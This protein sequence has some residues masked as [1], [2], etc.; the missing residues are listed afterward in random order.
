MLGVGE[1]AFDPLN[2]AERIDPE[3]RDCRLL[4]VATGFE[5]IAASSHDC[6]CVVAEPSS[7]RKRHA[8]RG[9]SQ[10]HLLQ[11]ALTAV[12]EHPLLRA[13]LPDDEIETVPVGIATGVLCR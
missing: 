5:R 12:Q 1:A 7:H 6:P 9:R 3:R 13:A 11:L 10:A 2:E 8:L 4:G